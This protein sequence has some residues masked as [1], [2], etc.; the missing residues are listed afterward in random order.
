MAERTCSDCGN[1]DLSP[2]DD[3]GVC[4]VCGRWYLMD[5]ESPAPESQWHVPP[6]SKAACHYGCPPGWHS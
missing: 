1:A 4:Q 3:E 2:A 5:E 6:G